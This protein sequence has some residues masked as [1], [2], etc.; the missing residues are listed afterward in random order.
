MTTTALEDYR[1]PVPLRRNRLHHFAGRAHEVLDEIGEVPTWAMTAHERGETLAEL[2]G[3]QARTQAR[4]LMLVADADRADDGA[5]V[6]AT[7]TAAYL[8]AATGITGVEA[9]RLV[10]QARAIEKHE[11]TLAAWVRG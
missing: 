11:P 8:R 1:T 4:I 9:S 7:N 6:G 5:A 10:R 2:M 3:L